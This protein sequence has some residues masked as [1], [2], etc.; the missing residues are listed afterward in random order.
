MLR[1]AEPILKVLQPVTYKGS[2]GPLFS[3]GR[4][5]WRIIYGDGEHRNSGSSLLVDLQ[6]FVNRTC[7]E[8]DL[9]PIYNNVIEQ[10]RRVLS[11]L[12]L[13]NHSK[14]SP[15]NDGDT[16]MT[17]STGHSPQ[18]RLEA[19]DFFVWQW[20]AIKDFVPLL[21][22]TEP[23]QEAVMIYAHVLI[24]LKKLE[25]QWW[26]EGWARH[27]MERVWATLDQE[28]RMWIQWPIEELGWV[29]P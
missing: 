15:D 19:W 24:M 8:P 20:E 11:R 9:L 29:P 2:L 13:E 3:F 14:E 10:L 12:V 25:N 27:M 22:G 6:A 21:R 1:G 5:R 16:D 26:L 23:R 17:P 18:P 28:H 7:T 4:G